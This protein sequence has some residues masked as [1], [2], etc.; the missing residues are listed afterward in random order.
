[1][2]VGSVSTSSPTSTH[3]MPKTKFNS[4]AIATTNA[5]PTGESP[6]EYNHNHSN[7]NTNTPTNSSSGLD[8][9][10]AAALKPANEDYS[11]QYS[12]HVQDPR[13]SHQSHSPPLCH[14]Y[15]NHNPHQRHEQDPG[16]TSPSGARSLDDSPQY[17]SSGSP[18][19]FSHPSTQEQ[20]PKPLS[21][22]TMSISSLLEGESNSGAVGSPSQ[23]IR[24]HHG[25]PT[26]QASASYR[27]PGPVTEPGDESDASEQ[28]G[29]QAHN[30]AHQHQHRLPGHSHTHEH[31][32]S[33][34]EGVRH[35][36]YHHLSHHPHQHAS[37][38]HQH[39][40]PHAHHRHHHPVH[41][42]QAP[43]SRG[44]SHVHTHS[45]HGHTH[46]HHNQAQVPYHH[47]RHQHV[48]HHHKATGAPS[49]F[50]YV[51]QSLGLS[52]NPRLKVNATQVYI[53][54]LIQLDQ[55][56]RAQHM[57]RSSDKRKSQQE[58]NIGDV[59]G[60]EKRPLSITDKPHESSSSSDG[61][62]D[63]NPANKNK[64][65]ESEEGDSEMQGPEG[66]SN[67]ETTSTS[68]PISSPNLARNAPSRRSH[69]HHVHVPIVQAG[70]AHGHPHVHNH[71]G[72]HH[73]HHHHIIPT[74]VEAPVGG[75]SGS[76]SVHRHHTLHHHHPHHHPYHPNHP[77]HQHHF[78][79]HPHPVGHGHGH[80]HVHHN[81]AHNHVHAPHAHVHSHRHS[82]PHSHARVK[83]P[84]HD[85]RRGHS[86]S[87]PGHQGGTSGTGSGSSGTTPPISNSPV[88]R[89]PVSPPFDRQEASSGSHTP[90]PRSEQEHKDTRTEYTDDRGRVLEVEHREARGTKSPFT[91]NFE[92]RPPPGS[93][94][95]EVPSKSPSH[96]TRDMHVD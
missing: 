64:T 61:V 35:R 18:S 12:G 58:P 80:A 54:Y 46:T 49:A 96:E 24:P 4:T 52:L 21:R 34:P 92:R 74:K 44:H 62:P 17:S 77:N 30:H 19:R 14:P 70:H 32:S 56:Q 76:S 6:R 22:S 68:V 53:S 27:E 40:H 72:H 90:T 88:L 79:H 31:S 57:I 42:H 50:S 47:H 29:N 10:A 43:H 95:R 20:T 66:L 11:K 2:D 7:N 39:A 15:Q 83:S 91:E 3:S 33:S 45:A 38:L 78:H 81:H 13:H 51:P 25:L 63:D 94:D 73:H 41:V 60:L 28:P 9:L 1:M 26:Y 65:D 87:S 37:S 16:R 85:H 8:A 69:S 82:H 75:K 55:M 59:D 84:V 89:R 93:V 48:H 67:R 36:H 86:Q 5:T 71:A 23:H